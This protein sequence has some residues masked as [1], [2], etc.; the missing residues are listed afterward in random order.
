[1]KQTSPPPAFEIIATALA[2]SLVCSAAWPSA[3]F[4]GDSLAI[5]QI[6][7]VAPVWSGHPV[8]FALLTQGKRQFVAFYDAQRQMT[9][10]QRQVDSDQWQLVRLPSQVGWD[11]HNYVTMTLD[12]GGY[13]HVSGNMHCVPLVYFRSTKPYDISRLEPVPAMIGRNEQHC[14][15][16]RFLRGAGQELLFTYRDGRSGNGDQIWNLY[17]LASKTW[18]RLLDQPLFSGEGRMNAYFAGPVRD[19]SGLFHLC[20]VWR[21]SADCATN[22]DLCYARSKDL[23]HWETSD[24]KPLRLPITVKT[25]EI[26]DPVPPG[27]GIINGNTTI[28]FDSKR[29]PVI[30]YHKF[31]AAGKTQFYNARRESEGWKIYQT[32]RWDYRWE[33]HGGGSI[34]FEIGLGP[35]TTAPDGTLSQSYRNPRHGSGIWRLDEATLQPLGQLPPRKGLPKEVGKVQSTWPGMSVRT[36]ED[37]GRS[38]EPGVRYLLR[39]EAMPPNRDRP[40]PGDPPLPSMLRVVKLRTD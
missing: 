8:G 19:P 24:G 22:H 23:V 17:D 7:D 37:L 11:S 3:T 36:A 39:W 31:D 4:A 14:T 29:R 34:P 38:D 1:L 28:G 33:F 9:I 27:G 32:S 26:V 15:Y 6:V 10:G 18:R 20:W 16:P 40:R 35:V 21:N 30:A 12:D 25:A 5:I 2:L 13:L